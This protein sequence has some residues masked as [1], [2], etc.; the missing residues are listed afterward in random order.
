[1]SEQEATGYQWAND[2]AGHYNATRAVIEEALSKVHTSMVVKIIAVRGGSGPVGRVD[3]Q[4]LVNQVDG[5]GKST[6]HGIIYNVPYLRAQ[7]GKAAIIMDP[8]VGDTG[9]ANF[10]SR[11]ISQVKE[12]GAAAPPETKRMHSMADAL[13]VGGTLNGTPEHLISFP[14]N[15]I[16]ITSASKITMTAPDVEINSSTLR[17]N[18]VNI[19]STHKHGG[20]QAGGGT[21]GTPQ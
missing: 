17:H 3:I 21:S 4:P 18:G 16:N 20:V 2:A 12:S 9:W 15:E 1:M 19:S 14:N 10:A 5:K 7:G 13:Y 11:D 8:E 6:P